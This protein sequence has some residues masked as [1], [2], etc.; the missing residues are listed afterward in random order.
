MYIHKPEK[1]QYRF[2][3]RLHSWPSQDDLSS[4]DFPVHE[5]VC[6]RAPIRFFTFQIVGWKMNRDIASQI[7]FYLKKS[8]AGQRSSRFLLCSHIA[9]DNGTIRGKEIESDDF[10]H[11]LLTGTV[12][13]SQVR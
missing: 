13:I 2:R 11:T 12:S 7:A 9:M 1:R 4:K 10:V 8:D 6:N 3:N 5:D